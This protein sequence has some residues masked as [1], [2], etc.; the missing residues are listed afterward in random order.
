MPTWAGGVEP[1]A[2]GRRQHLAQNKQV[3][4]LACI[5]LS[6]EFFGE[7]R[8]QLGAPSPPRCNP[9]ESRGFAKILG[10]MDTR[11]INAKARRRK[12]APDSES[13]FLLCVFAVLSAKTLHFRQ[14]SFPS[15]FSVSS[16][17]GS[18][19]AAGRAA[20]WRLCVEKSYLSVKSP[21][22]ESGLRYLCYLLL[23]IPQSAIRNPQS[24]I[25]PIR[26]PQFPIPPLTLSARPH[27][28]TRL[29]A[30]LN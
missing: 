20:P 17:S 8:V 16:C 10:P 24:A 14:S 21:D 11:L 7:S 28:V 29:S 1:T 27:K 12:G 3:G 5:R 6:A 2:E 19:V 15:V 30:E 26:N 25:G 4:A 9:S 18:L 13:G 22:S 23:S